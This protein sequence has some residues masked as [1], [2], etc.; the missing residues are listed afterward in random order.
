MERI[1]P[2]ARSDAYGNRIN[3]ID[4][5]SFL[6][7]LVYNQADFRQMLPRRNLWHDTTERLMA[8]YL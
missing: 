4:P 2:R 7:S 1:D 3:R 5:A 8:S 6:E